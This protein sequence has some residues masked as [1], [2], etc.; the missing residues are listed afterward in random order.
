MKECLKHDHHYWD[1]YLLRRP[2]D[3]LFE[4]LCGE[5]HFDLLLWMFGGGGEPGELGLRRVGELVEGRDERQVVVQRR[6]VFGCVEGHCDL[7]H[8][9]LYILYSRKQWRLNGL[10]FLQKKPND[11]HRYCFQFTKK[12][13][14]Y[15]MVR[16]KKQK[17]TLY[18]RCPIK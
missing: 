18:F 12:T 8:L 15:S 1:S 16:I 9:E 17:L 10:F 14:K 4:P 11:F 7:R 3:A 13:I 2:A 6:V 5:P